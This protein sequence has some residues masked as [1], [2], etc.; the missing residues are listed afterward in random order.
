MKSGKTIW[1][2]SFYDHNIRDEDDYSKV[3]EYIDTNPDKWKE[4]KYYIKGENQ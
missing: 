2:K 3:W 1:H 4:D